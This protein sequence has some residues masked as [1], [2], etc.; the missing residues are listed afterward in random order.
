MFTQRSVA[1][2]SAALQTRA[3][4]L[5]TLLA[6]TFTLGLTMSA[7]AQN[8]VQ[9]YKRSGDWQVEVVPA[10]QV[11]PAHCR[12]ARSYGTEE[13]LMVL[14]GKDFFAIDFS[15]PGTAALGNQIEVTY[16]IPPR[17]PQPAIARMVAIHGGFEVLR[18]QER[19]DEPGSADAIIEMNPARFEIRT[20]YPPA[21]RNIPGRWSYDLKGAPAALQL[22]FECR[23]NL[24]RVLNI[25]SQPVQRNM[26]Q[27]PTPVQ[28]P[29]RRPVDCLLV[30]KGR[31]YLDGRCE[32][33]A[34]QDGSFRMFGKDYFV[35]L[36]VHEKNRGDASWNADP[37]STH[38]HNRIGD[39]RRDGA[40]WVMGT[41]TRICAWRVGER[42]ANYLDK[43]A[44]PKQKQKTRYAC[45]PPGSI[46][47]KESK[48]KAVVH[49]AN[50]T[51][52]PFDIVWIDFDGKRKTYR[53]LKH[54]EDYKQQTYV[55]HPWILVDKQ[56][57]CLNYVVWPKGGEQLEEF[58]DDN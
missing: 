44:A 6:I 39:V 41:D 26:A 50:S 46:R 10:H 33:E 36:N 5:A 35:Y 54:G 30:V 18:V 21:D 53:T 3:F 7:S 32:Y 42:P 43:A 40:C 56:G 58:F 31:T 17:D 34:D 38:A 55:S 51:F 27:N 25:P 28:T 16:A 11:T 4:S 9:P 13:W 20:K 8:N 12:V 45:P 14:A 37:K 15:G 49:F 29:K 48:R 19:T 22:L 2:F 24:V 52:R 47:S 1:V 57:R 23:D